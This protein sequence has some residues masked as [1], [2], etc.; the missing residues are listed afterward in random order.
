MD[1]RVSNVEEMKKLWKYSNT[2]TYNYF[3]KGIENRNIEFWTIEDKNKR[4]LVGELYIFW[5]SEDKDEADNI[6]RAYLCAFRVNDNY[7][8]LGLGSKLMKKALRRIREKGFI[9]VT[10][11]VDNREFEKL[12][13]MYKSWGFVKLVKEK[14]HD[15]HYLNEE[16]KP[17]YYKNPYKLLLKIL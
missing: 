6:K 11:G 16:G 15:H 5:D 17:V 3:V 8:G 1:V 10:I 2:P 9:E 14:H 4:I 12:N 13:K 7:R